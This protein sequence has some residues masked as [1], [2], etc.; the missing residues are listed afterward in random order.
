MWWNWKFWRV[1]MWPLLS[2]RERSDDVGDASICSGVMPPIGTFA[3][4]ICTSGWR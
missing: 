4:I 2:G 1:V 3:R